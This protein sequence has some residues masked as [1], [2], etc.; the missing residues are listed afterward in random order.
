[1]G[2]VWLGTRHAA[3]LVCT[4]VRSTN[5]RR[6]Q[7]P[8]SFVPELVAAFG[9]AGSNQIGYRGRKI[10]RTRRDDDIIFPLFPKG[11]KNITKIYMFQYRF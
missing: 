6:E 4:L 1:M 3:H 10:D 9:I 8:S 7:C 5:L 11:T 2:G